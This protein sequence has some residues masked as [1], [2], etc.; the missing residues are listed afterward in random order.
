MPRKLL[1]S[2]PKQ[3]KTGSRRGTLVPTHDEIVAYRAYTEAGF[4]DKNHWHSVYGTKSLLIITPGEEYQWSSLCDS[5]RA[6]GTG[7]SFL[8]QWPAE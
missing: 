4:R 3:N 8:N 6:H 5:I 7:L 1:S 2:P